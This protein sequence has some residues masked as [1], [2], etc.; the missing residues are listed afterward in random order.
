MSDHKIDP[1]LET[2]RDIYP[3]PAFV[4]LTVTDVDR[5]VDWYTNALDFVELARMPHLVH[6]RRFRYQ[7][8]LL[9]PARPGQQISPGRGWAF[10]LR[11]GPG[12]E[13]LGRRIEEHSPG[14]SEGPQRTPWN[15]IELRC[16][17]PDGHL[18]VLSERVPETD[19][20]QHF[21]AEVRA[22]IVPH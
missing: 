19:M 4:T 2:T 14:S 17:D 3:M 11:G 15:V 13:D 6:L 18:V 21:S 5:S 20:D 10:S 7:D 22:S 1:E 12:L 8:I 16:T 9:L